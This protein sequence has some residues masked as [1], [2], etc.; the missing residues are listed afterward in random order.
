ASKFAAALQPKSVKA[1]A[2]SRYRKNL[3]DYV[4]LQFSSSKV[5]SKNQNDI[6]LDL[7]D[8]TYVF[9]PLQ[10]S[11]DT[12]T[13]INSDFSSTQEF[14]NKIVE[15]FRASKLYGEAELVFKQHPLDTS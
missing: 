2:K 13:L 4:K 10:L 6:K 14:I 9:V 15:D 12:Q 7:A 3:K 8:I 1:V 11:N 5:K